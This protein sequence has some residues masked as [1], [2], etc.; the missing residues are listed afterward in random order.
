MHSKY[1]VVNDP[2][3]AIHGLVKQEGGAM[4]KVNH[5]PYLGNCEK[6]FCNYLDT[7]EGTEGIKAML[8]ENGDYV[9]YTSVDDVREQLKID[10]GKIGLR[11]IK[12][13]RLRH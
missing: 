4:N 8:K 9:G 3:V 13:A 6:D 12:I 10:A 7:L 1:G 5:V 2:T 11:G